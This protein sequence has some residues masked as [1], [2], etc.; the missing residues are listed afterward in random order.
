LLATCFSSAPSYFWES[1][2]L[3]ELLANQSLKR[4]CA[5]YAGWSA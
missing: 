3:Q 5:S 2:L 4:T 1:S